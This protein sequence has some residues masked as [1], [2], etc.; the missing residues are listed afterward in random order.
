MSSRQNVQLYKM[1]S[2]PNDMS[3]NADKL[4]VYKM[5]WS[6]KLAKCLVY[7]MTRWLNVFY[8]EFQVDELSSWWNV[9]LMKCQVVEMSSCWNV[10]L[11]KCQLDEMSGWQN[12]KLMKCQVDEMSGWWNVRLMKCHVD[13]MSSWRNV[14][15]PKKD[16]KVSASNPWSISPVSGQ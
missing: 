3:K 15:A 16:W 1:S 12:V 4:Q 13:K 7:K 2:G 8:T 14:E 10:K 11:M 9:K 6:D 5:T